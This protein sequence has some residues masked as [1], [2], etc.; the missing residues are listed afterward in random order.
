MRLVKA[1]EASPHAKFYSLSTDKELSNLNI[2]FLK[3][4]FNKKYLYSH[5]APKPLKNILTRCAFWKLETF[6]VVRSAG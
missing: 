3:L 4:R 1:A 2:I 5:M 6:F